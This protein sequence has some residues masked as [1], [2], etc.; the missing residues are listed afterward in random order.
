MGLFV[1]NF[2][3]MAVEGVLGSLVAPL[4]GDVNDNSSP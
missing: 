4:E 2:D 1:D 3:R